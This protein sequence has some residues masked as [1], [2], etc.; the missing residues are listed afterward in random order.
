[1]CRPAEFAEYG[2]FAGFQGKVKKVTSYD[3]ARLAGVSQSTVSR[4]FNRENAVSPETLERIQEVATKMGYWPN[5]VARSLI[6][7]KSNVI[8]IVMGDILNPFYPAVLHT[9]TFSLQRLGRRVMLL[10]VPAGRD[11]DEVLPQL[12][13]YQ[14]AGVVITSATLSSRMAE[15][16]R[17][18]GTPV[19]LFNRTVRGHAVNSVCCANEEAARLVALRLL[20][21]GHK[22][23]GLIGGMASTSTHIERRRAFSKELRRHGIIEMPEVS[24]ENTY[25]GGFNAAKLLLSAANPPEALFC[26]SDIMALGALDAA[27]RE[28]S[29]SVPGDVSIVGFDDIALAAW[30]GYDLTTVRQPVEQM[31]MEAINILL[32]QIARADA[33]PVSVRVP[34]ELIVR[35]SARLG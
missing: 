9:F 21:A 8:G 15:T 14:V 17:R 18:G 2:F 20:Q 1:V 11:V 35:S 30:P 19:V 7:R 12:M 24:G 13:Q 32:D 33:D 16:V 26:I 34:G 10:S 31:A 6:S 22:R 28:M 3:I 4:A 25:E 23:F 29:L 5:E 27:R